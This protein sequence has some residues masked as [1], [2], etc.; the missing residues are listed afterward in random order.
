MLTGS[1][2]F[3]YECRALRGQSAGPMVRFRGRVYQLRPVRADKGCASGGAASGCTDAGRAQAA[4][5]A[6]SAAVGRKAASTLERI[7]RPQSARGHDTDDE[8]LD[9]LASNQSRQSPPVAEFLKALGE[10][11]PDLR[12]QGSYFVNWDP[13]ALP[14]SAHEVPAWVTEES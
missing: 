3:S 5:A 1:L 2:L 13:G 4:A 7:R 12:R 6:R 10:P 11:P 8:E 9:K 14:I